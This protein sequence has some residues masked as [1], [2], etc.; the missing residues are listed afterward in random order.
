M[1]VDGPSYRRIHGPGVDLSDSTSKSYR[2]R[3][4][5]LTDIFTRFLC[6]NENIA[7]D[8]RWVA[9]LQHGE[10]FGFDDSSGDLVAGERADRIERCPER[11]RRQFD[12]AVVIAG[13]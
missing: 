13:Q 7:V 12:K 4:G 6:M 9:V 11:V 8:H 5:H 3:T 10:G 2:S 1:V